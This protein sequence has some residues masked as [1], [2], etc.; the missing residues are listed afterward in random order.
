MVDQ[1]GELHHLFSFGNILSVFARLIVRRIK[2]G[3]FDRFQESPEISNSHQRISRTPSRVLP[4]SRRTLTLQSRP[5]SDH[6]SVAW[7]S[8]VS[9]SQVHEESAIA[10]NPSFVCPTW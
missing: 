4:G 2:D 5:Y 8:L 7:R 10:T 1:Q 6:G 3:P 9:R